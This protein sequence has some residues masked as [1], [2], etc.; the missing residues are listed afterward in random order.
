MKKK[1]I[2]TIILIIIVV[3]IGIF[4][5]TRNNKNVEKKPDITQVRAICNL[6][7]L[8]TYYHNVAKIDKSAGSGINHWF[9]KDRKLWIEYT[10]TAKIGIDMSKVDMQFNEEN[11]TIKLPKAQ[12][13]SIDI[14]EID[15]ESYM[16]SSDSWI[17]KNEFTPEEETEAIN[18]AQNEIKKNVENNSQLL[19]T[20]Q[21]RAK[22]LIEQYLIQ[23]GEW[24]NTNYQINWVFE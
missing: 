5:I 11:I 8:E 12:L 22:D 13:L 14:G 24:T 10:G 6:A 9:E 19:L 16:Y 1:I 17:N 21:S 18:I 4:F 20:A 2:V 7:T 15:K 23:I 3:L